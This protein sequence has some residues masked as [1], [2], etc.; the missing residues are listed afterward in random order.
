MYY[1]TLFVPNFHSQIATHTEPRKV[2]TSI[3]PCILA[4]SHFSPMDMTVSL[5]AL[6]QTQLRGPWAS[7]FVQSRDKPLHILGMIAGVISLMVVVTVFIS[8]IMF[9]RNK[10]SNRILPHRRIRRRNKP[11]VTFKFPNSGEKL[12]I[13]EPEVMVGVNCSNCN[14]ASGHPLP[15]NHNMNVVTGHHWSPNHNVSMVS[16]RHWPPP[17]PNAPALPPLLP[18]GR[19]GDRQWVV[20]TVLGTVAQIKPKRN[21]NRPVDSVNAALVSELK[22]RLD[23]RRLANC[24]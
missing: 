23:Q 16:G 12:L 11:P 19:P 22:M 8:T 2:I 24:S 7:F 17:P 9:M 21:R 14:I 1:N 5:C 3:F 15:P 4:V 13:Q 18:G 20:P 10:K 6:L